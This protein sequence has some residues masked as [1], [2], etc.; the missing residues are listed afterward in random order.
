MKNFFRKSSFF[1]MLVGATMFSS[2]AALG[3]EY[4]VSSAGQLNA[5]SLSAGDIVTWTDGTYSNQ[6]ITFTGSGTQSNPIILKAETPGGVVLNGSSKL[7]IYGSYLI[8]E[9][10]FWDGGEGESDHVEFRKS[11]SNSEF[12]NNCTIRNCGFDNLYTPE[13]NKSRWIVLHGTNNVVENC[14]FVNKLSAGACI[15]VELS[16]TGSSTPGHSIRNNYFYNI[17]P[18]DNFSTNSG[19]CEAIR[20]GV[21]SYQSVSAQVLVEGN[22]FKAADG[23]NEIITNKSADNTFLHNTFR[24]C[25]GSLVLRHGARAH[26]EGNFF[27]GEGKAK[28][29]GIRVSDR[30][31]V[32]INNYMQ[33]LNNDGDVW[34]NGITLVGGGELSGGSGNGYQNVDN[35]LVAFNTIY[36][37]DDPIHYNDRNSYDPTG[38][39]AYN[40]VYSTNGDIVSGDISGTGQG[41]TYVGNIFGGS[42][43][44]ISDAGITEGDANFSASGEIYKPSSSGIAANAAGS[45][46]ANVVDLDIEGLTRPNSNMDVGAH[47]VSGASGSASYSPIADGDVGAGVGACFLDAAGN[48]LSE[49]GAVGE[50]LTVSSVSEFTDAGGTQSA[51][52]SSNVS[53]TVTDNQSWISVNPTSGSGSGNI[54]ITVNANANTSERTGTVTISGAGVP[55]QTISVTQAAYVAPVNVTGV[56]LTPASATLGVGGSQQLSATITPA[57]ATNQGVTYSSSNTSVATVSG[58]G[59]VMAVAEGT[60]TI[61]VTTDDGGYTDTSIITVSAPS[62]GTNLALNKSVSGTGT[63]DGTNVPA[64]LVDGDPDSRWAVSGFPQSATVDLGAV[65]SIESTELVCY[66]DRAYQFIIEASTNGSSYSTIVDRSSN[67]TPGSNTS[68]ITDIFSPVDARYVRITVS[69]AANYTGSWVSLEE[70][71]VFGEGAKTVSVTGVSVTPASASLIEGNTH[72]LSASVS[73][74]DATD[75]GVAWSSSNTTVA[76]VSSSGLVTAITEGSATITVTTNDGG[77]TDTSTITVAAEAPAVSNLALNKSVSVTSEQSSNPGS[78]LVDGDPDSRWSAS[79]FPQSATIDLGANCTI[80]STEVICY[81]GRAYQYVIEASTDGS[82]YSTIVDRSNN[83]TSGTNSS[84]I[85]DTF[86]PVNARYVRI[87]VSGANGYSGSWVSIEELRVFGYAAG[88]RILLAPELEDSEVSVSVY[89]V[90]MGDVLTLEFENTYEFVSLDLIDMFGRMQ[91]KNQKINSGKMTLNVDGLSDGVY[92]LRLYKADATTRVIRIVK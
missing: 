11:G 89:P 83:T 72:Q 41:M 64:N 43:I 75:Q 34:N 57:D 85:T 67:T 87:T 91:L 90:P 81:G 61:T 18:K 52:I 73:P 84:P 2:L 53:W 49:C 70:L 5:L 30:D 60:A 13:P 3:A 63:P 15:L 36:N 74:S 37:S 38:V 92:L 50:Y 71:R 8:I 27:L 44:G 78:N 12:A 55:D 10:F 69:G 20:I 17:T 82:S 26:I 33:G 35:I 77:F 68:A 7:N 28:S 24:N 25:R 65:F 45:T 23:E 31:H 86:S 79:G 1:L 14:S 39:I 88:A 32:I 21:S 48:V 40:L 66:N 4:T 54:D 6:D 76:T 29:G 58:S 46:Y 16:Y 80:S 59:L 9:G 56:S 22:Y 42:N 47:E 62:S 51:A 19:D